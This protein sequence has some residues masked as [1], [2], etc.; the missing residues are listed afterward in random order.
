[1]PG[2][3]LFPSLCDNMQASE[4]QI[5]AGGGIAGPLREIAAKFERAS[6]H[7]LV[8]RF[9]TTPELIRLAMTGGPFDLGVVP[10]E[11]L[12]DAAAQARFAPGPTTD[13]AR[14]GLG[15][16]VRSGAPRPDISTS[17]A[18]KQTLLEA[19]SIATI[20]ASAAGAHFLRICEDLGIGE[21]MKAKTRVQPAPR[22][23]VEAVANGEAELG[24]FLINVLIAPGLD[25]V[26]PFPA[27][28]QQEVI[29]TA[30]VAANARSAQAAQAFISYVKT[31]VAAAVL[32]A[33][34]MNPV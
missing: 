2:L 11:V 18:L 14:V 12:R 22:Q 28:L 33:R 13:I 3:A 23:I 24:V 29:F 4:L 20:P 25:V 17:E 26:G 15:I 21:A 6:G 31:P 8:L 7:V 27:A 34:G 1:M 19:Q 16:A 32:K 10:R 5:L 9:G 30:A